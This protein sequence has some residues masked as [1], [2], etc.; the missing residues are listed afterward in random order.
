MG[1]ILVLIE[2]KLDEYNQHETGQGTEGGQNGALCSDALSSTKSYT[3]IFSLLL[4]SLSI[5]NPDL[6]NFLRLTTKNG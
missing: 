3:S 6:H 4:K 2:N 5:S 1:C